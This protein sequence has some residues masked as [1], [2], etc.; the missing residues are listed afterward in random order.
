MSN[1]QV[2]ILIPVFN[3]KQYISECIQSA[4]HQTC[5][6]FEIV[7]VDNASDD[8]TWEIC[9]QFAA[10]D[11]RVRIFRNESNIGPVRNWQRCAQE[12]K[13]IFSKILFSDD[14]LEP[15]C[16]SEMVQKLRDPTVALVYS[17]AR[18]G[19][20]REDSIII[21]SQT[22]SSKISCTQFLNLVLSYKAPKSPGAVLIRTLDLLKNLHLSFPTFTPRAFEK[23]GAGPDVLLL[24]LTSRDYEYV[25][26]LKHP[27]VFFRDHAASFS[28]ENKNNEVVK[29]YQSAIAFFLK[30]NYG[31]HFW[32]SYLAAEWI[33]Q[34]RLRRSW[35]NPV[36]HLI[37]FEGVGKPSEVLKLVFLA[38]GHLTFTLY[39]RLIKLRIA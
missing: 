1:P 14:C 19:K 18:L 7:V 38:I 22:G 25:A 27:L 39:E 34:I 32:L 23:N 3:R 20:S 16:L 26:Y 9:Q 10:L 8:G 2:S 5:T 33:L 6:D 37:E 12:A 21:Y 28:A 17:D 30:K 36:D 24:L 31:D 11:Q 15:D 13:G 4:L 35:C 29:G